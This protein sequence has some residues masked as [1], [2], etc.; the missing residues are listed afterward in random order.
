MK[1]L[2]RIR[3]AEEEEEAFV[4]PPAAADGH[5]SDGGVLLLRDRT[6]ASVRS[7]MVPA[8]GLQGAGMMNGT[9]LHF[10]YIIVS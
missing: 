9:F 10:L 4:S 8:S 6:A 5:V 2:C 3:K 7:C 1:Q